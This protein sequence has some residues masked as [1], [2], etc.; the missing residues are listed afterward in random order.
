MFPAR[1]CCD[2]GVCAVRFLSD[3]LQHVNHRN[4]S[5]GPEFFKEGFISATGDPNNKGKGVVTTAH[6][7]RH[8][9]SAN[10]SRQMRRGYFAATS[11]VDA[12][13]GRVEEYK[14]TCT[15]IERSFMCN[16]M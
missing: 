13:V 15:F 9:I 16:G 4:L 3:Q 14:S 2:I 10:F 6:G 11:F 8:P 5:T 12:Q 1:S 7:F